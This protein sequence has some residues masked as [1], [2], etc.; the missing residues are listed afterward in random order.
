[1]LY[2]TA[3]VVL[4]AVGAQAIQLESSL[5]QEDATVPEQAPAAEAPQEVTDAD[6]VKTD[7]TPLEGDAAEAQD[8]AAD[9]P[10]E[11]EGEKPTDGE[12]EKP[13]DGEGEGKKEAEGEEKPVADDKKADP[14]QDKTTTS[15]ATIMSTLSAAS[16]ALAALA[17]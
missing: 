1:M 17:L 8:G 11:G 13:E 7:T 6:A 14:T 4:I 16:I 15:G 9:E 10:V 12:G 3:S 5:K 2:K